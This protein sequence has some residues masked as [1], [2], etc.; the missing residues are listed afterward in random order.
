MGEDPFDLFPPQEKSDTHRA[1]KGRAREGVARELRKNSAIQ[2]AHTILER[3]VVNHP[4]FPSF[5]E[6]V[7]TLEEQRGRAS[8]GKKGGKTFTIK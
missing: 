8:H 4:S 7:G 5:L 2:E 1:C 3:G 6:V